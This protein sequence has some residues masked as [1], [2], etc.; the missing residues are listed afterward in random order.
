MN[1]LLAESPAVAG[2]TGAFWVT[3]FGDTG[4]FWGTLGDAN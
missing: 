1:T 2:P 4:P 3:P